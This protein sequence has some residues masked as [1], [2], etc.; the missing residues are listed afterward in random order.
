MEESTSS[1]SELVVIETHSGLTKGVV[2]HIATTYSWTRR[3]SVL[4]QYSQYNDMIGGH[5]QL[6]PAYSFCPVMIGQDDH[7][8]FLFEFVDVL[9]ELIDYANIKNRFTGL[10]FQQI[11]AAIAF[12]RKLAQFNL[13]GIDIDTSVDLEDATDEELINGLRSALTTQEANVVLNRP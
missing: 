9:D 10:S 8:V 12:L 13:K 2:E 5:I 7:P 6:L 1:A 11:G 3:M 4:Q